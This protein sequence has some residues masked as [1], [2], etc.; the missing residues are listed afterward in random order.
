RARQAIPP[1]RLI[2]WLVLAPGQQ[3][4]PDVRPRIPIPACQELARPL[5]DRDDVTRSRIAVQAHDRSGENPRVSALNRPHPTFM[6]NR[7]RLAYH[8][9]STIDSRLS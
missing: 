6:D 2:N 1:E 9:A 4:D 5:G 8:R 7:D 3:P